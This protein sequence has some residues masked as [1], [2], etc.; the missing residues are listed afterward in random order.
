MPAL[1]DLP[2]GNLLRDPSV[3]DP[4]TDTHWSVSLLF[5]CVLDILPIYKVTGQLQGKTMHFPPRLVQLICI[6]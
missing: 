4:L 6:T 5:S 3:H 2:P 1:A